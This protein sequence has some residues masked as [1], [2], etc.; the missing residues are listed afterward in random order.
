MQGMID[1]KG[2]FVSVS[3]M[4]ASS[5]HDAT[6]YRYSSVALA[7]GNNELADNFNLVFDE[8]YPC[9]EQYLCPCRKLFLNRSLEKHANV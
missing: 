6:A 7:N 2:K 5:S 9:R 3:S 4:L 1:A 8:A